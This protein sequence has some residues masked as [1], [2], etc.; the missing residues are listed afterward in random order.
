M[1]VAGSESL[2]WNWRSP[3]VFG[4][5]I[6]WSSFQSVGQSLPSNFLTSHQLIPLPLEEKRAKAA[7]R[8]L[9]VLSLAPALLADD[10]LDDP[11]NGSRQSFSPL[12]VIKPD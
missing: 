7:S 4:I 11:E 12:W 10:A 9:G 8:S 1:I 5:Q 6:S 2:K 3:P